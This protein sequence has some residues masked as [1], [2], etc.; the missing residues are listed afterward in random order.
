MDACVLT[1][2][3]PDCAAI[4]RRRKDTR[5]AER[6]IAHYELER[7]FADRLRAAHR[8]DYGTQLRWSLGVVG[9]ALIA[10]RVSSQKLVA[11]LDPRS[12]VQ[13]AVK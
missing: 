4:Q 9:P 2:L 10:V 7:L 11:T 8:D 6:L 1:N 12:V 13:V 3:E 5:P